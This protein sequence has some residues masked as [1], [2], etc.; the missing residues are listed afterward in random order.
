DIRATVGIDDH[1]VALPGRERP[2]VGMQ[3][4]AA[5]RL[6]AQYAP[7]DHRYHE[8]ATVREPPQ[9]RRLLR[10]LD[11]RFRRAVGIHRD[12]PAI[13]LVGE[14]EAVLVP[15]RALRKGEAVGNDR[16][17]TRGHGLG[18]YSSYRVGLTSSR[19]CAADSGSRGT[20]VIAAMSEPM[21]VNAMAGPRPPSGSTRPATIP[22]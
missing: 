15:A 5:V 11:D 9:P 20:T 1:V 17:R 7:V 4:E 12:D 22:K 16:R 8:H 10:H 19:F 21:P 6:E 3:R 13:V 14:P 2:E 18:P